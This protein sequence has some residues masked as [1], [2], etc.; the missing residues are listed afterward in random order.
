MLL[1]VAIFIVIKMLFSSERLGVFKKLFPSRLKIT[2]KSKN[3]EESKPLT[4]S[5]PEIVLENL[6]H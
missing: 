6:S 5:E 4:L 3:I 1:Y 2:L